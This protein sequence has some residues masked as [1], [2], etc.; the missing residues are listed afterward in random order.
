MVHEQYE[1]NG[2]CVVALI[3]QQSHFNIQNDRV[4]EQ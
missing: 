1:M 4:V 3:L 2:C